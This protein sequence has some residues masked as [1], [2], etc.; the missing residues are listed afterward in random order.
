MCSVLVG[1][2]LGITFMKNRISM[3]DL[4]FSWNTKVIALPL[5]IE[6][7]FQGGC[8]ASSSKHIKPILPFSLEY[9]PTGAVLSMY[10]MRA[11]SELPIGAA[12]RIQNIGQGAHAS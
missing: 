3:K 1:R 12:A 4:I 8:A 10:A 5:I 6:G 7:R 9:L 2:H 11:E